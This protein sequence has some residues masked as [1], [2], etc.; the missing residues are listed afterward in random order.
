MLSAPLQS[1]QSAT[2]LTSRSQLLR[3]G[4]GQRHRRLANGSDEYPKDWIVFT[5]CIGVWF[6]VALALKFFCMKFLDDK[7]RRHSEHDFDVAISEAEAKTQRRQQKQKQQKQ[8]ISPQTSSIDA[9][10]DSLEIPQARFEFYDSDFL[11]TYT[12]ESTKALS[13]GFA[14]LTMNNNGTGYTISGMFAD[15]NSAQIHD[16][17]VAYSGDAWWVTHSNEEPGL[18][19]LS[20]GTFNFGT[21]RFHGTWRDNRGT[22]GEYVRFES[23]RAFISSSKDTPLE[24]N[25]L[26]SEENIRRGSSMWNANQSLSVRSGDEEKN[27]EL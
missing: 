14:R 26:T 5:T 7:T 10:H 20:T 19:V 13:A 6:L 2:T 22:R 17:F 16:G 18:R 21:N 8:K 11:L 25:P 27:I 4:N 9:S 1:E 15:A 12:D 24:T 3:G 23:T